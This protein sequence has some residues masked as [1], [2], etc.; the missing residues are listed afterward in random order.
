MVI[1]GC[2]LLLDFS[3]PEHPDANA[4]AAVQGL[5]G[6]EFR[7]DATLNHSMFQ[8]FNFRSKKT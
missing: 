7:R 6:G 3:A 8:S 4:A 1:R 2:G 5:L